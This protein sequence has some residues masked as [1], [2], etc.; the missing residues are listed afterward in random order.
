MYMD[1]D[2]EIMSDV[3]P[4]LK[5]LDNQ[6]VAGFTSF[7]TKANTTK[8]DVLL[9]FNATH[10]RDTR[11]L[12]AGLILLRRTWASI[13]FVS[14][15]LTYCQDRRWVTDMANTLLPPMLHGRDHP[16]FMLHCPDQAIFSLLYKNWGF[17]VW[18]DPRAN[19]TDT[20]WAHNH[21]FPD[22]WVWH[23]THEA[24]NKL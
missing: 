6:D 7:T 8:T 9:L 13:G 17:K 10:L 24:A 22:F 15:W 14:Q 16:E 18:P 1:V 4:M 12:Y 23:H 11:Q 19:P 3:T 20:P 5:L 21:P 2:S